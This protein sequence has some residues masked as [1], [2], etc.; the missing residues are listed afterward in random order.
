MER[1]EHGLAEFM[2]WMKGDGVADARSQALENRRFRVEAANRSPSV[3][4]GVH[5]HDGQPARLIVKRN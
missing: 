4:A 2:P 1:R 5:A 3:A